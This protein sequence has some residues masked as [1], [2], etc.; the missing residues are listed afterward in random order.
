MKVKE[1]KLYKTH[2]KKRFN[3]CC[4]QNSNEAGSFLYKGMQLVT[5]N[6]P[7]PYF[8]CNGSATGTSYYYLR[9][10]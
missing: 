1:E 8:T 3:F 6:P 10:K 4:Q 5:C 2:V 7:P 9:W